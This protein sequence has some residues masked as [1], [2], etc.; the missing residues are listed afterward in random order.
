MIYKEIIDSYKNDIV[1]MLEELVSFKSVKG[2]AS[3][4]APFGHDV[5]SIFEYMLEKGRLEG[6]D[7]LNVDNY[8]GH[9]EWLGVETDETGEVIATADETLGIPVHLDV[10]PEGSDWTYE[11]FTAEIIDGKM[12]GRG[13][14]DNKNSVV[15]IFFALKALKE[16]GFIP[17]KNIRI[18]LGLDEETGWKGMKK[19][20][21]KVTPPDFGFVPDADFPAIN[22]EKGIIEFEL[23]KK[24][25][26]TNEKGITIRKIE[27]GNAPNMV[28]DYARAV[29][30]DQVNDDFDA[31][32]DA[33]A[34]FRSRRGYKINGKGVGKAF[35]I[36]TH[37]LSAHGSMPETGLNAISIMML[38]LSEL[39]IANESLKEFIDFYNEKIG[40]DTDGAGLG[41]AL[42][43][44]PSGNL[45]L[46][47][48]L[49]DMDGE[50]II[51]TCDA[52][53][54]VTMTEDNVYD[55]LAPILPTYN[56][57]IVKKNS[58][59]SI[60]MPVDGEFISTLMDVYKENTG[61]SSSTPI[62]IGG[63]T[64]ARA[65]PNAVAFGPR[66]PGSPDLMHQKD[67]YVKI[68]DL[69]KA[70]CIY[71]DAIYRLTSGK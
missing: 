3:E 14:T 28:P 4:G 66:F 39:K 11:P 50:A 30:M 5:Q 19:Y 22:G 69:I 44:E 34:D 57:G 55:A 36:I 25:A 20:L 54:P 70:A 43:D 8:G 52:R 24:L 59:P 6:F 21:E 7:V 46:N 53:Y 45:S 67:E 41:I 18:I 65:I 27:G 61:D 60:Y 33:I 10:V 63:G 1:A 15:A 42:S 9:I 26:K 56:L 38:F 40:F 13:T 31:V 16:S 12:Y 71:A 2:D 48:G 51:L 47:I 37:G 64:Y 32:K 23:A 49:V 35:E 58:K 29:I 62:V 68:D 17:S